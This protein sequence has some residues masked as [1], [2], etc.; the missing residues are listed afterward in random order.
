MG[1]CPQVKGAWLLSPPTKKLATSCRP[2]L[3][4]NPVAASSRMLASTIG[5]PVRPCTHFSNTASENALPRGG[6]RRLAADGE[7]QVT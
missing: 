2:R 3:L 1:L 4:M 5:T 6:N 7:H